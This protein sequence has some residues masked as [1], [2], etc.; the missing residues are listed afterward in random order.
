MLTEVLVD[1]N[2]MRLQTIDFD[3][4]WVREANR[5]VRL[6]SRWIPKSLAIAQLR[7]ELHKY[8]EQ[9]NEV[10]NYLPR[11]DDGGLRKRPRSLHLRQRQHVP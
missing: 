11:D 2:L 4:Q 1:T 3:L 6:G 9:T 10:S 8:P 5:E 7:Q